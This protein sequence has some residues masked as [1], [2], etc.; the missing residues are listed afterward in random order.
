MP[1]AQDRVD[2]IAALIRAPADGVGR[3]FSG[4]EDADR[5]KR[6]ESRRRAMAHVADHLSF[7][8]LAGLEQAITQRCI[9]L[10][11]DQ[12]K[13]GADFH[14]WPKPIIPA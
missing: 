13:P 1:N 6:P 7:E 4:S 11:G 5:L 3:G 8:T 2:A 14:W 12:L 9:P 10:E